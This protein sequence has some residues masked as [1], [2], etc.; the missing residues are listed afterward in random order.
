VNFDSTFFSRQR[1]PLT[2]RGCHQP[3]FQGRAT[4]ITLKAGRVHLILPLMY[5]TPL[6]FTELQLSL[7][8]AKQLGFHW[9]PEQSCVSRREQVIPGC[10][11]CP[12][13]CK[14]R[15]SNALFSCIPTKGGNKLQ[16]S[17][18][19][20]VFMWAKYKCFHNNVDLGHTVEGV[21]GAIR[22]TLKEAS[23]Y[24]WSAQLHP[25]WNVWVGS[26][27]SVVETSSLHVHTFI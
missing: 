14:V 10:S 8:S 7:H 19:A 21:Q 17:D 6:N 5:Y 22:F 4:I 13:P 1:Y 20:I 2:K 27:L 23:T 12:E 18:N 11:Q 15:W 24:I 26:L 25:F 16:I 9:N 3:A